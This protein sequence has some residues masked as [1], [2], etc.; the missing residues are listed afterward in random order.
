MATFEG[1]DFSYKMSILKS[2]DA[3]G[4]FC[5]RFSYHYGARAGVGHFLHTY[6]CGGSPPPH[7]SGWAGEGEHPG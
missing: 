5:N 7:L 6:V 1:N 3:E 4:S 2:G